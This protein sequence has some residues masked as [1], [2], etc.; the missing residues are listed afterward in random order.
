MIRPIL[1]HGA[2]VLHNPANPVVAFDLNLDNLIDDMIQTMYAASGVGLAAPQIGVGLR[3]FVADSSAGRSIEEL[4]A[5]VNPE[6]V[7]EEG[8]QVEEEG[9]LSLPGFTDNVTR[10]SRVLVTGFDREGTQIQV[11][12]CGLLARVLHH[13]LDHLDGSLFVNRL[14]GLRRDRIA[15]RVRKL[16]RSG[17]W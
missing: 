17:K 9:C 14:R 7:K 1:R 8:T 4:I 5:I 10:P 12:G 16:Q 15:R 2:D 11:E 6:I 13:E 3:V